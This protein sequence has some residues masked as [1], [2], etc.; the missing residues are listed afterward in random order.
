MKWVRSIHPNSQ[1]SQDTSLREGR[2]EELRDLQD[3]MAPKHDGCTESLP[4]QPRAPA[5]PRLAQDPALWQPC[6]G[7]QRQTERSQGAQRACL[8]SQGSVRI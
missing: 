5:R 1:H 2:G 4:E 3:H 8:G 6:C 7:K